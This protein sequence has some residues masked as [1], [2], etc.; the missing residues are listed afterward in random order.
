MS[1]TRQS[2]MHHAEQLVRT[3]GANGFSYADLATKLGIR[4]ASVHYHFPSKNDLLQN[5]IQSYEA[6]FMQALG[7]LAELSDSKEK[8]DGFVELYRQGLTT[9]QLC[10]CGMLTLDS[11]ALTRSMQQDL[12]RFFQGIE[13]WLTGLFEEGHIVEEWSLS[14]SPESEA[15]AFLALVQGAQL[16][17]RNAEKEVEKFDTIVLPQ[18]VRYG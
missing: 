18:L 13:I 4:K 9:D 16:I 12:H 15:K 14:G 3:R 8:M 2:I 7:E 6:R 11:S 17:A 1:D 10:L 5:L